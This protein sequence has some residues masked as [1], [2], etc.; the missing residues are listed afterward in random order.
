[1]LSSNVSVD[2]SLIIHTQSTQQ[3][4]KHTST[5][6]SVCACFD[7]IFWCPKKKK[8]PEKR[9]KNFLMT[10]TTFFW[11]RSFFALWWIKQETCVCVCVCGSFILIFFLFLDSLMML[12]SLLKMMMVDGWHFFLLL[13]LCHRRCC[14]HFH[15][16][17]FFSW[18][19]VQKKWWNFFLHESIG[20]LGIKKTS[21]RISVEK[22]L[23]YQWLVFTKIQFQFD[24]DDEEH[25]GNGSHD[26]LGFVFLLNVHYY[27]FSLAITLLKCVLKCVFFC[28]IESFESFS[29]SSSS[30][31]W[32]AFLNLICYQSWP[33]TH[34]NNEIEYKSITQ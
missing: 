7:S 33:H 3:S 6:N 2:I 10:T 29:S 11:P 21:N 20:F 18:R 26:Q 31:D 19:H 12:T 14:C 9:E 34:T 5:I 27:F 23:S 32:L 28:K 13:K 17:C 16:C 1:M 24:D 25:G 30:I 15:W 8:F 4:T 22:C